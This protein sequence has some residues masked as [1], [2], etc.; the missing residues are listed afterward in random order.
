MG[1]EDGETLQINC[2]FKTPSREWDDKL[3][4]APAVPRRL[5]KR[6]PRTPYTARAQD[7]LVRPQSPS[8]RP[9]PA[10][11]GINPCRNP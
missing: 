5:G 1:S 3:Q 4:D 11:S 2:S 7:I 10:L 6:P 9:S 8:A